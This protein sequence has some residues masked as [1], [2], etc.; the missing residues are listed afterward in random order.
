MSLVG[1]VLGVATHLVRDRGTECQDDEQQEKLLHGVIPFRQR[2]VVRHSNRRA[3]PAVPPGRACQDAGG[4]E[5]GLVAPLVFKTSGTGDPRPVGSIPAASAD[6][7][8]FEGAWNQAAA[9]MSAASFRG[10]VSPRRQ[11]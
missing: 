8:P 5:R 9:R 7:R 3:T 1:D 6:Q 2:V 4:G 11:V 10:R